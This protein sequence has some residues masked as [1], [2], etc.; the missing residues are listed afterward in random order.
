MDAAECADDRRR[1]D[2]PGYDTIGQEFGEG[3]LGY[4]AS[5]KR[6]DTWAILKLF[7]DSQQQ[8]DIRLSVTGTGHLYRRGGNVAA[9][10][11]FGAQTGIDGSI[12]PSRRP[13]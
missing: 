10:T 4:C 2:V 1:S 5:A 3:L 9:F 7:S 11:E 6:T 8:S 12:R 13:G